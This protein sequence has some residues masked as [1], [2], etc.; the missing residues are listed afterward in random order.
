MVEGTLGIAALKAFL[1]L[2]AQRST[3]SGGCRVRHLHRRPALFP[4][5]WLLLLLPVGQPSLR[6]AYSMQLHLPY[7]TIIG[8]EPAQNRHSRLAFVTSLFPFLRFRLSTVPRC[9]GLRSP[10]RTSCPRSRTFVR[11]QPSICPADHTTSLV[12]CRFL[13]RCE[14]E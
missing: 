7:P 4:L 8:P 12:C 5:H 1:T 6:V 14:S 3:A 2:T 13:G 11:A 9:Q 10:R